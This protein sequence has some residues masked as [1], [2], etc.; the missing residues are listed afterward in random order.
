MVELNDNTPQ[1]KAVKK[2]ADACT[3]GNVED[4]EPVLSKDFRFKTFPETAQ[5]PDLTKDKYIQTYGKIFASLAKMEVRTQH[6]E[7]IK[8]TG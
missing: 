5:L 8:P 2:L 4:A 7:T 1:L 3:S 6:G